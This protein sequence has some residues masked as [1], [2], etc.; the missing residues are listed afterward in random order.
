MGVRR[1]WRRSRLVAQPSES[2][3]EYKLAKYEGEVVPQSSGSP[4]LSAQG[5]GSS[6]RTML[7]AFTCDRCG[8]RTRS[9]VNPRVYERGT[10]FVRCQG[11]AYIH[12]VLLIFL[13]TNL[14]FY[15]LN[16]I[17]TVSHCFT[18]SMQIVDHLNVEETVVYDNDDTNA[19]SQGCSD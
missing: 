2:H 19:T 9:Y 12:K 8:E 10:L 18:M 16:R 7:L 17:R 5:S 15:T 6:R 3:E 13:P 1:V 4:D 11:C 14:L